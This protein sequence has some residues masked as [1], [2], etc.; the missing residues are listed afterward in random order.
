[1]SDDAAARPSDRAVERLADGV[2]AELVTLRG[3]L[4][5]ALEEAERL[6]A[7][8]RP[9]LAAVVI[10]EQRSTLLTIHQRLEERLAEAAVERAAEGAVL[11]A[12]AADT[13]TS[14]GTGAETVLRL[15]AAAVAAVLGVGLLAVPG[16]QSGGVSAAGTA[17]TADAATTTAPELSDHDAA[18]AGRSQTTAE[19]A[20]QATTSVPVDAPGVTP[21]RPGTV[22]REEPAAST[23]TPAAEGLRLPELGVR[24]QHLPSRI[25]AAE[26]LLD[27]VTDGGLG[28][29]TGRGER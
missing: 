29:G 18:T 20:E 14:D 3:A 5:G 19:P 10:E 4:R 9:E 21:T 2:G 23:D 27:R 17:S 11:P 25:D 15:V 24:P 7:V 13:P 28:R 22:D 8:G 16:A 26:P 12:V 1:M 6:E